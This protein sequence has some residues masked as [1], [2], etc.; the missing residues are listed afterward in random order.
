MNFLRSSNT[1]WKDREKDNNPPT[2]HRTVQ[3]IMDPLFDVGTKGGYNCKISYLE[4]ISGQIVS[5]SSWQRASATKKQDQ[6]CCSNDYSAFDWSLEFYVIVLFTYSFFFLL[7]VLFSFSFYLLFI[8][9][10]IYLKG[11]WL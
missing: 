2:D 8:F 11:K 9:L 5:P 1:R 3:R 10:Y 4:L 7:F 6:F